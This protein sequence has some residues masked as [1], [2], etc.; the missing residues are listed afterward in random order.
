MR[1]RS[2]RFDTLV[3]HLEDLAHAALSKP[4]TISREVIQRAL[5]DGV[6]RSFRQFVP[7]QLRRDGGAFFTGVALGT[8]ALGTH[9]LSAGQTVIDPCCGAGDLLLRTTSILPTYRDLTSTISAWGEQILGLELDQTLIRAAR[10]RLVLAAVG[11]G[12]RRSPGT[13]IDLDGSFP[14][15]KAG[16]G[17]ESK[18]LVGKAHWIVVN[19]PYTA[20]PAP[21]ECKWTNGSVSSAAVF[22]D[23]ILSDATPGTNVRAILPDVLRTG[24]RYSRWRKVV[25]SRGAIEEVAVY[26]AFDTSVD[27]DVFILKMRVG[28]PIAEGAENVWW[29]PA[30]TGD[31]VSDRFKISVG[32]L[33]PHRHLEEG[34]SLP[35][36]TA[37]QAE[38][39]KAVA[40]GDVQRRFQG[41]TVTPP[42][43]VVRRTS[44]P[45]DRHRATATVVLGEHPVAVENHL[46]VL[47]PRDQ[48]LGT[49]WEALKV[50]QAERTDK[51]LNERIRCRHLTVA[52]VAEIPW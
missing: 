1:Y 19:P 31:Q 46:I 8:Q 35:Y 29:P 2:E 34:P 32:P 36:L 12:L 48:Q 20:M 26:G 25:S 33:V 49:C 23:R 4:T 3:S 38:P 7:L 9:K 37:R 27:V 16:D 47:E 18:E 52:A 15:L 50:L 13:R 24:S 5:D 10:A 28:A 14:N 39:W 43:V 44:S 41:R 42:F 21:P 11:R 17:L 51:W 30:P 6:S 22:V 45:N 40:T